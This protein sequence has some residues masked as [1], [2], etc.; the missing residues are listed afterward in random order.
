M[1]AAMCIGRQIHIIKCEIGDYLY[2]EWEYIGSFRDPWPSIN[3]IHCMK[4]V[5]TPNIVIFNEF[6]F[7]AILL[8]IA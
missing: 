5:L 3:N 7:R 1:V 6:N 4:D 2:A 8:P